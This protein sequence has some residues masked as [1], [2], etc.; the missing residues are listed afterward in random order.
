M[1]VTNY[2]AVY[3]SIPKLYIGFD[4]LKPI[5]HKYIDN[6]YLFTQYMRRQNSIRN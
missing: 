2:E 4:L 5:L 1:E 3:I 6:T